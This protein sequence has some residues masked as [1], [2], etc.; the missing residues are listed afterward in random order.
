MTADNI[1]ADGA[2]CAAYFGYEDAAA[3][4]VF[5]EKA[6]GFEKTFAQDGENG[7]IL[8]AEMRF[9][10]GAIMMGTGRDEQRAGDVKTKP[11]GRGLYIVTDDVDGVF[12]RAKAAGAHVVWEPHDTEFG[13]RRCRVLDP[14]GYEWSFGSYRPGADPKW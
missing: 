6:F 10:G 11:A 9:P 7:E 4:L 2:V 3:A 5:L 14:E 12:E 13:T 1:P 8:H